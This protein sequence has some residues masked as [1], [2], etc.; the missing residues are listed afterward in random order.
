MAKTFGM[1]GNQIPK[2]LY[3]NKLKGRHPTERWNKGSY[4]LQSEPDICYF[5]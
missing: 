2:L 5:K 4:S 3:E 1:P